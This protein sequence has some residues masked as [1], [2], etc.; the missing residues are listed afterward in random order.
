M[1]AGGMLQYGESQVQL[2]TQV[3]AQRVQAWAYWARVFAP[4]GQGPQRLT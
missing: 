3:G 1:V 2:A 4:N